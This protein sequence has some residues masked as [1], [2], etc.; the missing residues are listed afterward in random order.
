MSM[1]GNCEVNSEN[2]LF[3]EIANMNKV[4]IPKN[5]CKSLALPALSV[6]SLVPVSRHKKGRCAT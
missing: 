6:T 3:L 1:S 5:N 2:S 4:F